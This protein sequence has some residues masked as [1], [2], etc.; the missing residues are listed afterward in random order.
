M[1]LPAQDA[2]TC[3]QSWGRQG[4]RD[5]LPA[6]HIHTADAPASTMTGREYH[7]EGSRVERTDRVRC[8][9]RSEVGGQHETMMYGA[10]SLLLRFTVPPFLT[11]IVA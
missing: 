1:T 9:V 8:H 3:G 4:K 6:S 10:P 7:R 5:F 2:E 11:F